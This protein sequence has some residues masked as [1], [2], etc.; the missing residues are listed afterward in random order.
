MWQ[1][2]LELFAI[3]EI[4]FALV[5]FL[6]HSWDLASYIGVIAF[7]T[8]IW[9]LIPKQMRNDPRIRKRCIAFICY[10][11]WATLVSQT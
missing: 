9:F 7:L 11:A 3:L 1:I 10:G 8:R 6:V 4:T 5:Y 2:I